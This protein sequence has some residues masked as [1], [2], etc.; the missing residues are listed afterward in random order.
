MGALLVVG[1]LF[2]IVGVAI[3]IGGIIAAVK[4]RRNSERGVCAMGKVVDLVKKNCNPGSAGVYCPV[5]MFIQHTGRQIQFESDFG[6]MPASHRVGQSIAIRYDPANPQTA[7]VDSAASNW[8]VSVVTIAVG[9]VFL[10]LGL[11]F[12]VIGI[13][14]LAGK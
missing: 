1:L 4:Q 5:V 7:K 9:A 2:L 3:L 12:V 13:I 8:L 6:T 10:V 14:A 11:V